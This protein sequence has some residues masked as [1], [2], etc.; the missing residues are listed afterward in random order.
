MTETIQS[1]LIVD[2]ARDVTI[3][4]APQEIPLFRAMSEAFLK[5]PDR[6][7]KAEAG[8]DEMLGF[9]VGEAVALMTPI[10][11]IVAA[12]VIEFLQTE[13]KKALATEGTSLVAEMTKSMF[14][15]FRPSEQGKQ[16]LP[17]LTPAQVAQVRKVAFEKARVLKLPEAKASLLADALIGEL[18]NTSS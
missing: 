2:V 8:K 13:V 7:L 3:Q 10:V 4:I 16:K 6:L 1:Q 14:K 17:P 12:Q 11:L 18:V 9:G 15:R 5:D